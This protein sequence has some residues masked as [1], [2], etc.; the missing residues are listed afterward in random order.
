MLSNIGSLF[1]VDSYGIQYRLDWETTEV[2]GQHLLDVTT[3]VYDPRIPRRIP[4]G[5]RE[6]NA[7]FRRGIC[8]TIRQIIRLDS[9]GYV[10]VAEGFSQ[11]LCLFPVTFLC[12]DGPTDPFLY[13][14]GCALSDS[15]EVAISVGPRL[16]DPETAADAEAQFSDLAPDGSF[17]P[18]AA[19][20]LEFVDVW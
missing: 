10:I 1:Y 15:P 11:L 9:S 12:T 7:L 2:S 16:A 20:A 18:L 8:T 19:T 17:V 14:L 3:A 5:R 6:R 13:H 4:E